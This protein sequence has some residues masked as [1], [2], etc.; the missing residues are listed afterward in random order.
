MGFLTEP[1]FFVFFIFFQAEDGI[2]DRDVTGVQT[3]ALPI[4]REVGRQLR[5]ERRRLRRPVCTGFRWRGTVAARLY[6]RHRV[7][8]WQWPRKR[9]GRAADPSQIGRASCRERV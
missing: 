8:W 5:E 2:R 9:L 7:T 1:L 3:C 6:Q 4:Y